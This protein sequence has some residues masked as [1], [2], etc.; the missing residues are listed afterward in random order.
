LTGFGAGASA[1]SPASD[2]GGAGNSE[3][4]AEGGAGLGAAAASVAG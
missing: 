2:A 4:G 3:I 1:L